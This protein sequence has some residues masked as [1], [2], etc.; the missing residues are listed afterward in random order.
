MLLRGAYF[1]QAKTFPFKDAAMV[2][3]LLLA[4]ALAKPASHIWFR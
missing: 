3:P 4:I 1:R 2:L